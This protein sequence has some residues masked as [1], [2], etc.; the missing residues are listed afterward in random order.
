MNAL[1]VALGATSLLAIYSIQLKGHSGLLLSFLL[2][3]KILGV[4]G[5]I[6]FV[7]WGLEN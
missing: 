2:G 4:F 5:S 6:L 1:A 7:L 3:L